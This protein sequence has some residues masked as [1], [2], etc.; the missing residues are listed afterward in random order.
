MIKVDVISGFLGAGKTT[1]IKKLLSGVSKNEKVAIIENEFGEIGI[2]GAFLKN[3]GIEIKE[4]NSGCICCSLVGNF[5][6]SLKE[7]VE[8]YSPNRIIIEPSGVGKLSDV[9]K[10]VNDANL[11]V[12]VNIICAVVDG[13][14]CKMYSKNFG[15]F[16]L[17]QIKEASVIVVSKT[18]KLSEEKIIE[19]CEFIKT[20]NPTATL[21]TTP[22]NE[23][24]GKLLIENLEDGISL[25]DMLIEELKKSAHSH[26][27]HHEHEECHCHEHEH[28]HHHHEHG[29]D[30]CCEHHEHEHGEECHC[31]D[32]DHEHHHEHG[33][34]CH[35]HE[36]HHEH[37][38]E[39][40]CHEHHHEHGEC[41]CH[42]H[43]HA[44]DVFES[45]AI[46]T[47][48]SYS[49]NELKEILVELCSE[50][51]GIVLRAKGIV[52]SSESELWH[53]FDLVAG[54]F[55]IRSGAPD[56]T[57]KICVIGSQIDKQKIKNLF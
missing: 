35:C 23:L 33:E 48:K 57:G 41:C 37:G 53:Y 52:K 1:L 29:E 49:T 54:E 7:L 17:D 4:I 45:V 44:E 12:K 39:C 19:T 56:V 14:K 40:H 26:H 38:E 28:E 30:C 22:I 8:K 10:A 24:D 5:A 46:E 50:N 36:H 11:D 32:H 15:E 18:D 47:P 55:E 2:D 51:F 3:S 9:V 34:E 6:E 25:T 20:Y 42:G 27:H 43:H 31:H 16:Y 13:G 21:I